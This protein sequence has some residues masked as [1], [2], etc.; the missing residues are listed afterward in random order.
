MSDFRV[1]TATYRIQF[2]RN[3]TFE[4]CRDLVAY[5]YDLGISD[6][7]ASPLF[8]ARRG[9]FH[10]Y[11]VT[12]PMEIN[13]EIGSRSSFDS[14]VR[15]LKAREMGLLFDIVPNHMA[16]S[17]ENPWW[18]DVL[19]NGQSSP[20]SV[21]FD[22]DWHP[23][24]RVLEGKVLLP[25]LGKSYNQ[26]L[27]AGQLKL[28]IEEGGFFINYYDHKF[29][30]DPKTYIEILSHGLDALQK[31]LGEAHSAVIG[32]KGLIILIEHLPG[33][34]LISRSKARERQ[35]DKEIIKKSLWL[36]YKGTH[37]VR[38]FLDENLK[39]FNGEGDDPSR[40]DLLDGLLVKQC[41]RLAFWQ[42]ALETINY[43]RFFS[44]N[45][46]I[47][48]RIEDPH[49]FETLKHGLLFDLIG[50]RKVSGIRIDHIDGLYDPL[51]YL[52]RLQEGLIGEE[53]KPERDD[54]Y[55]IVVE[56]ILGEGERLPSEWPISGSTGYDYLNVLNGLFIDE[57]G[58]KKLQRFFASFTSL[59]IPPADIV[60]G[61]K[62]LIMETLFGGEIENLGFY[63]SLLAAGDRQ[64]RDISRRDLVKVLME[65]TACL[66][67]YRTYI[68]SFTVSEQ[69]RD[70]IER[71][72]E[73]A[74]RRNPDLNPLALD[75]MKRL[76]LLDF[77]SY[78]TEEQKEEQLRF[79]MRWQ[80]FT[81]P[82]MA[83]GLEDTS[84]YVYNPLISINEVGTSF[85]PTSV[86]A[87]HRF[88]QERRKSSPFTMNATSTHDTKRSEDVR[89]RI[90]V[91][92]EIVEEWEDLLQ[93]WRDMNRAKK[94]TAGGMQVPDPNEEIYLYQT[95][96]GAWPLSP[97][98]I[99]AFKERL[100]DH[101]I[102][103]ARE[104][105]IHTRWITPDPAYENALTAFSASI[106][107]ES[108]ENEFLEYFQRTQ[109]RLAYIGA[110][111]SL[112][113]VVLKIASPGVPDF[114]QGME[115][116]DF[117][118][119]DPDNR[120]PVD[121]KKRVQLL[122]ELK[123]RESKNPETLLIE[124]LVNWE[125]G[126]IKLFTTHKALNFRR[127]HDDLFM[128]GEYLPL[129]ASGARR[130]N[131]VAFSRNKG[132]RWA[133]AA[134]PRL[135][136]KISAPGPL[137]KRTWGDS[138]LNFPPESPRAWTNIFTGETLELSGTSGQRN[139]PLHKVFS[140]FPVAL[141]SSG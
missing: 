45:D 92:S 59:D 109:S 62:K 18:M 34:R 123:R 87:F 56:K 63:L 77:Q 55:Y 98:E 58:F 126:R 2:S 26:A 114:Y 14:L 75:F 122:K 91:L 12:N 53:A 129:T 103:A 51:E 66:P 99:P 116:W 54:R 110:L 141:L 65:V 44:I 11:S 72:I 23:P 101:I 71:T 1:P 120:R 24:A 107:E 88:N 81:G 117:S 19:E 46:L 94:I 89:A 49:V 25:I 8:Q 27:E 119:V 140:R 78:L 9:S 90:N 68:R 74:R 112:S 61:K 40:F 47:G 52:T 136:A 7:Y 48:I 41:Y 32:L 35:R 125:D 139:L 37:E 20:Y 84:L 15:R 134:V 135:A 29:S 130:N 30:L 73:E 57:R 67:V 96:I 5:L 42:V 64:A 70:T 13:P 83:K 124:L 121:F 137:G 76:L 127:D 132:G 6:L 38:N 10:G 131:V 133:V 31:K 105:M 108:E 60:H 50:E 79:V 118:L 100:R 93:R 22:I 102:K 128:E 39:I 33:R 3:F 138:L 4:A 86:E 16:L 106:L 28:V 95:L 69:D 17:H 82:I 85:R 113:Q 115:L 111:N 36:L 80:Q 104:A 97:E 43:R 21:F